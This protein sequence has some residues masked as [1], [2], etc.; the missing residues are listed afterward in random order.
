MLAQV[1]LATLSAVRGSRRSIVAAAALP[2]LAPA[3]VLPEPAGFRF[4]D[5]DQ[6]ELCLLAEGSGVPPVLHPAA[7]RPPSDSPNR[8]YSWCA[9]DVPFCMVALH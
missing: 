7:T 6:G 9:A 5:A 3:A 1:Q 8:G 4:D 2:A